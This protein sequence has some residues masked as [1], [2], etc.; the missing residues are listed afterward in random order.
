MVKQSLCLSKHYA[1]KAWGS[2]GTDPRFLTSALD[3]VGRQAL[4]PGRLY[5]GHRG[6][7]SNSSAVQPVTSRY[8][9]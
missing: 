7:E 8:T 3:G 2:G 4:S 5:T 1:I 9:D 6:P